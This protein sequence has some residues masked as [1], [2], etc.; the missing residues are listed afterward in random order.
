MIIG[1]HIIP[2]LDDFLF[3]Q[4]SDR[5][6][7]RQQRRRVGIFFTFTGFLAASAS[8]SGRSRAAVRSVSRSVR[9]ATLSVLFEESAV[10][11]HVS[12]EG[13]RV[14][15]TPLANVTFNRT[16]GCGSVGS[17]GRI[18]GRRAVG[19]LER[20]GRNGRGRGRPFDLVACFLDLGSV[21]SGWMGRLGRF[22]LDV[23]LLLFL[24]QPVLFLCLPHNLLDQFQLLGRQAVVI[25]A[26]A[27]IWRN[28]LVAIVLAAGDLAIL[29]ML[30]FDFCLFR[31]LDGWHSR[32]NFARHSAI[33]DL[34][35]SVFQSDHWL[36][37]AFRRHTFGRRCCR[38]PAHRL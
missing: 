34:V 22:V 18:D 28:L 19:R 1:R 14:L 6:G 8:S 37:A 21:G 25:G 7:S 10:Q 29:Q 9:S 36:L 11:A 13:R 27:G 35:L 26:D 31:G 17:V 16:A 5:Y 4:G 2:A 15:E 3:D 38:R 24:H 32:R 33:A 20:I 30:D 12:V 23:L